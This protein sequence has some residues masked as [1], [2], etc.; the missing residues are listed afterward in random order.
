M[1][2]SV[3]LKAMFEMKLEH[4]VNGGNEDYN[5]LE[6]DEVLVGSLLPTFEELCC[7]CLQGSLK[8]NILL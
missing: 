1:S 8:K 2:T 6:H 5:L 7:L 3:W 4:E